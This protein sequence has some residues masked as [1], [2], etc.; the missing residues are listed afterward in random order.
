M[1]RNIAVFLPNWIGDTVMATPMLRALRKHAGPSATITGIMKPYVQRVL[2]GTPWLDRVLLFDR[3]SADRRLRM[4]SVARE[5]RRLRPQLAIYLSSSWAPTLIGWWSG[6]RQRVACERGGRSLLLTHRVPR[7]VGGCGASPV[8]DVD[9]FLQLA[10][11]VGCPIEERRL[12]LAVSAEDL[13]G[14]QEVWRKLGLDAYPHVVL[15][16]G[17]SAQGS[18]KS[19]PDEHYAEL[20]R[21]ILTLPGTAIL[22]LCGPREREASAAL[23]R[24][25]ADPRVRSMATQDL[26]LGTAKACIR[27]GRLLVTTDSGPRHIAAAFRIPTVAMFGP[28][29]AGRTVNYNPYEVAVRHQVACQPC[30]QH[31]CPLQHNACMRDLHPQMVYQAVA[32]LLASH[33]PAFRASVAS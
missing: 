5:L 13:R 26:S 17:G 6:A 8:S 10:Y 11:A 20:A 4:W 16:N 27:R 22:L 1:D 23:E 9:Y 3:K 25:L 2:D 14:A 12:E 33:S 21:R 28:I 18:A 32:Q 15:F 24:R 19:W 7:A 31:T 29:D 30:N